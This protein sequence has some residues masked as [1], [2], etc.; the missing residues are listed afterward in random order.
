MSNATRPALIE[1]IAAPIVATV[2]GA[3]IGTSTH[4]HNGVERPFTA[5]RVYVRFAV[6]GAIRAKASTELARATRDRIIAACR[7]AGLR[8]VNAKQSFYLYLGD[9]LNAPIDGTCVYFYAT[10]AN[11]EICDGPSHGSKS[12]PADPRDASESVREFDGAVSL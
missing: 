9:Y 5:V 4:Y 1:H 10:E 2:P 6:G 12:C 3:S 7:A 11:C 8:T